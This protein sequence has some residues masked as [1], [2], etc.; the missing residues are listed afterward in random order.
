MG[1]TT[2]NL[3][4][5]TEV[6]PVVKDSNSND[7]P[8]SLALHNTHTSALHPIIPAAPIISTNKKPTVNSILTPVT[9][10]VNCEA[11]DYVSKNK[12]KKGEKKVSK[13]PS[14]KRNIK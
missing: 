9:S 14:T 6:S 7:L 10:I 12:Y 13:S 3:S 8:I 5:R 2:M 4:S 1:T 11:I